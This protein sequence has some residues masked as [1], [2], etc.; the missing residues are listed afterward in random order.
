MANRENREDS[1]RG[2][3]LGKLAV[4]PVVSACDNAYR[5]W[6]VPV[7][8]VYEGQRK[9]V[10]ER[11]SK[12]ERVTPAAP[13]QVLR[14]TVHVQHL[15]EASGHITETLKQKANTCRAEKA[16]IKKKSSGG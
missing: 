15:D 3:W 12:R 6:S 7:A 1:Q 14:K 10:C 4:R 5:P 13:T 8:G 9:C 16:L 11:E 2:W